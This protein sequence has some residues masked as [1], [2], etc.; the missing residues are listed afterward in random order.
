MRSTS[1]AESRRVHLVAQLLGPGLVAARQQPVLPVAPGSAAGQAPR[2][3]R[4]ALGDQRHRDVLEHLEVPLHAV[5]ARRRPRSAASS[6]QGQ[7]AH[8][9]RVGPLQRLD[10]RVAG[11]GHARLHATHPGQAG[12]AHPV[13]RPPSRSRPSRSHRSARCSWSP[14]RRPPPGRAPPGPAPRSTRRPPAGSPPRCRPPPPPAG[15]RPPPCPAGA[16]TSIIRRAP[17]LAGTS[18][19]NT[20]RAA[21]TTE[22]T[23]TASTALTLPGRW[24]SVPVKSNSMPSPATVTV[25]PDGRRRLLLGS[26]PDRVQLV[27]EA[28]TSRRAHRSARRPSSARRGRAPRRRGRRRARPAGRR[29]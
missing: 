24:R 16:T 9:Q 12:D 26:G 11:V 21:K 14:A 4:S 18:G 19:A 2:S 15:W 13:R 23:V 10:R 7:A 22:L 17:P 1:P 5:A 28:T 3:R 27:G 6:A 25:H 29:P 8:P 20:D